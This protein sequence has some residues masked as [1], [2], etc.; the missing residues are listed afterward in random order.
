MRELLPCPFC[1]KS[2]LSV[3]Y[4]GQPSTAWHIACICCGACGPKHEDNA[5]SGGGG[6]SESMNEA[7]NRR[8]AQ[9]AGEPVGIFYGIYETPSGPK[10]GWLTLKEPTGSFYTAPPSLPDERVKKIAYRHWNT[11]MHVENSCDHVVEA[12]REALKE[13]ANG[14]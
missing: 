4:T 10:E 8:T 1:G 14:K 6:P 13:Q 9:P 11:C 2:D 12:I 5:L 7:W 3:A